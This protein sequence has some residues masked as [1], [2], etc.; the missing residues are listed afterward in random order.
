MIRSITE[1]TTFVDRNMLEVCI[2]PPGTHQDFEPFGTCYVAS[3]DGA[4]ETADQAIIASG[5][6]AGCFISKFR[7]Q[8]REVPVYVIRTFDSR[9]GDMVRAFDPAAKGENIQSN[10]STFT[11]LT[12]HSH[13]GQSGLNYVHL[14][15][16][17]AIVRIPLED[18]TR[19][20]T[21]ELLIY[22][23]APTTMFLIP[24]VDEVD[25]LVPAQIADSDFTYGNIYAVER[26]TT[27]AV[28]RGPN[29]PVSFL[30]FGPI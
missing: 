22:P 4:V 17:N 5:R 7:V 25:V 14:K 19:D 12:P 16:E 10:G 15:P 13:T 27:F 23:P 26:D 11:R 9:V 29:E 1:T 20:E 18:G 24:L 21:D 30:Y 6:F 8:A 2:I 28:A 3:I